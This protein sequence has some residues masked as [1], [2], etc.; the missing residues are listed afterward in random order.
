MTVLLIDNHDSYT[1]NL[2]HRVA[3]VHGELPVVRAN[4]AITWAEIAAMAPSA[5]LLSPGPGRPGVDRD[6]GVGA[7][8]L[9]RW[10]GPLLGVCLGHQGLAWA[11]G[12]RIVH[13]PVPMHGRRSPITHDGKGIFGD[14][15][16][17]FRVVRYH[18]LIAESPLPDALEPC[19]WSDDGVIQALRHRELPHA[20]VQ[21]HPESI[22]TEQGHALIAAF[23]RQAGLTPRRL[24]GVRRREPAHDSASRVLVRRLPLSYDAEPLFTHLFH[25]RFG[26]TWLDSSGAQG[27]NPSR[28]SILGAADGPLGRILTLRVGE[29]VVIQRKGEAPTSL[30]EDLEAA[31][32]GPLL[33]HEADVDVPFDFVGG[34]VGWLGYGLKARWGHGAPTPD[35]TP[36]LSLAF[37]DRLVVIDHH[38]QATW[39]VALVRPGEAAAARAW[40]NTTTSAMAQLRP[41][42]P[43]APHPVPPLQPSVPRP[44]YLASI[45]SCLDAIRE[46]E[47]YEVC[48][49]QRLFTAALPDPLQT[50]RL[51]RRRNPA[52]YAAFLEHPSAVVSSSSPEKFIGVDRTGIV[53]ARPIKGTASRG[54]TPAEDEAAAAALAASEKDRAENL[55]IVDLLRNDLGRVCAP[56]SVQVPSLFAVE[57]FPTVHHLVSTIEGRLEDE[58]DA[59]DAVIAAFPPGSMTGAPKE[60]TVE[61][62]DA[63]EPAPRGVYSGAIGTFSVNGT[64]DWSVVIRTV[65]AEARKTTV[66]VGG[67]I[68]LLSRPEAEWEEALLK[69]RALDEVLSGGADVDAPATP[70]PRQDPIR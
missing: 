60:R 33:A 10:R 15:P 51:L 47:S 7:E 70:R 2:A 28:F 49:T 65:V 11:W 62:L 35:S 43:A 67:A 64:A 54:R 30:S 50:H 20:G 31:I 48:L 1:Y 26:A 3:E 17:G 41:L 59:L 23:L 32:R 45:A 46:G 9:R 25:G 56:G 24:P 39:L 40:F 38:D 63:L 8:I 5:I 34:W 44:D 6:L 58:R 18:S 61:I 12:G 53:R 68:T 55:M 16:Q 52:P 29:P 36:D 66:G 57:A 69:A 42:P 13:A 4:D 19:A 37:L 14:L 27:A 21:F 22:A